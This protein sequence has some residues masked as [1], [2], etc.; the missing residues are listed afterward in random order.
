MKGHEVTLYEKSPALGGS[1]P[2]A[3]F[4]KGL[5]IEDIPA[6]VRYLK[7]QITKLG[8]QVELG[9]EVDEKMIK[10][11]KPDA[12]IV[13]TGGL[14]ATPDITGISNSIVMKSA[15]LH[16]RIKP[17]LRFF[18]PAFLN[19]VTKSWMPVGKRV[20][21]IGGAIQGCELAEFLV[22]RGRKVTIVDT[23]E[24]R[25]E[26]MIH[27]MQQQLFVWFEKNGVQIMP[28]VKFLEITNKGMTIEN[29][30]G[31]KQTIEADTIITALPLVPNM[32][33]LDKVK[34]LVPEVYAVGDCR[35]PQL[36]VDAIAD[37]CRIAHNL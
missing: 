8:V 29:K 4:V 3:A 1:M 20:I 24:I 31:K 16:R 17:Y 18:S 13:A 12:V 32:A 36:I 37:G 7:G 26:G 9:R 10:E 34:T 2:L 15:D 35:Q 11:I 25:G 28:K 23:A 19:R 5:E 33:L 27:H 22:K 30:D 6:I 14:P 21:V